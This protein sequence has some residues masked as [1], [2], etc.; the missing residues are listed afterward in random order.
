VGIKLATL[1][2]SSKKD[3]DTLALYLQNYFS[4]SFFTYNSY[5]LSL[6]LFLLY[7]TIAIFSLYYQNVVMA[8]IAW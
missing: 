7:Q 1:V 5:I 4:Y 8:M 3:N 6:L 2:V